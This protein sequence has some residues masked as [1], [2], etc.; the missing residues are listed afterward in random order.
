[1]NKESYRFGLPGLHSPVHFDTA[2]PSRLM[3]THVLRGDA[4]MARP[5][6]TTAQQ[7]P[8]IDYPVQ[9][10]LLPLSD[11]LELRKDPKT[12]ETNKSILHLTPRL[13]IDV[14]TLQIIGVKK[15]LFAYMFAMSKID[16]VMSREGL[17]IEDP[18][19]QERRFGL[20]SDG[21][22][23]VSANGKKLHKYTRIV[24]PLIDED[25]PGPP[26]LAEYPLAVSFE[27][28]MRLS[29]L[30]ARAFK[31]GPQRH[32]DERLYDGRKLRLQIDP[33]VNITFSG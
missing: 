10:A 15:A 29:L 2:T 22:K 14:Q 23:L 26:E 6:L 27:V 24:I 9:H 31:K 28:G 19:T 30:Q 3:T 17:F 33:A 20:Y 5:Y 18:L 1:M 7:M 4:M 32:L 25:Q 8:D 16:F 11:V 21:E 12:L 13:T